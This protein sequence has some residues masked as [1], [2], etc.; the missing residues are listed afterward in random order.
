MNVLPNFSMSAFKLTV[1][2]SS[3]SSDCLIRLTVIVTLNGTVVEPSNETKSLVFKYIEGLIPTS[4]FSKSQISMKMQML[5][6]VMM[7]LL[8]GLFVGAYQ[9]AEEVNDKDKEKLIMRAVIRIL[10]GRHF[11]GQTI[12]DAF[13]KRVFDSY[14]KRIDGG[15][16]FITLGDLDLMDDYE[17]QIDDQ[18]EEFDLEFFELSYDIINKAVEKIQKLY[19]TILDQPFDFSIE[20]DIELDGE[21]L[22]YAKDDEELAERWQQFLK[23]ETLTRLVDK[24]DAQEE[25]DDPEGGKKS[26]SELE[27]EARDDVREMMDG[28]FKRIG[29][30]RRSDRFETYLNSITN[31][32]DPHTDYFNPK[33]KEDFNI[34]MSRRLEGIGARLQRS[35]EYTKVVMIVPGGP[36]WK[37]KELQVDDMVHKVM[38][39]GAEPVDIQGMHIDDVVGMI[40]GKKGTYVTL[41]VKSVDGEMKDIRIK[42]EEVK[43]DD[44]LAQSALLD[45]PGKVEKVGYIKLPR[46]YADFENPD[47]RSCSDDVATE[48][49]KLKGQQVQGVILDLRNNSGGS[50]NDVVQMSGLFIKDGPIVQVKGRTGD[51][52]VYKDKDPQVRYTGPLIVMVNKYSA[53]ASE[54]L[55]AALQ[56]YDRAIVVGSSSTFGKGTV[57]RF[58]NLD[59]AIRGPHEHKPLGELKL[60]MQKFYRI[61]GGSTQLE[62]VVPDIVLPERN[63]YIDIG[64]KRLDYPMKWTEI[65]DIPYKQEVVDLSQKSAIEKKS[66]ERVAANPIFSKVDANA[67]RVKRISD[68]SSFSLQ[69][70]DYRS[71]MK[72]RDDEAKQY[73][74]MFQPIEG[75]TATNLPED[76]T[77]IQLDSSRISRNEAWIESI[78]K[79]IYIDESLSIMRDMI[80]AGVAVGDIKKP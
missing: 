47:G 36:A 22:E 8:G 16:R 1:S 76:V 40:R 43:L 3:E 21:K 26:M 20:E 51:P 48:L 80:E 2:Y 44:G 28:W 13:S 32:F 5:V 33:A 64:E 62:G 27:V 59:R 49:E 23:Y 25:A 58:Y 56:D 10:E 60:T 79:D 73:R 69:L 75:L 61:N 11:Q 12:D 15:K 57:Q 77:E 35:G 14:L 71:H 50:L 70:D 53:S 38:Q 52:Y 41:T 4:R 55:A 65:D 19:P 18:I 29:E 7:L 63:S 46:F 72:A 6:T 39:D 31:V 42:R 9:P 54:I 67:K 30:L 17:E 78:Q 45:F 68:E 74:K 37:Q 66:A 24:L 34:T